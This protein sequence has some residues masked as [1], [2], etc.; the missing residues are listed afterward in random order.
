MSAE[1]LL[2]EEIC[3]FAKSLFDRG[4]TNGSSGNISARLED[5]FLV[6]P[7]G[8][9]FGSLDPARLAKLDTAQR[10]VSGDKPTKE[11]SLH[12]AFY[13][14]RG[15]QSGAVVHLHSTHSV[16]VSML[17]E[18]DPESVFPPLTPYSVM[19][20]GQVKLLPYFR[21]GDAAMGEAVQRLAGRRS[22]VLLANH[23]PVVAAKD[24][25][26]AV[27][28]AEELEEVAKLM[29]LTR[30]LN[31]KPLTRSDVADLERHFGV[32]WQD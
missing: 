5:G 24:L 10:F 26:A 20:L 15:T 9:S 18:I 11:L 22:A 29:L 12:S 25:E 31:P 32:T 3:R 28:A 23:G 14:T 30:Q 6:T 21:P 8:S 27:Y 7:T 17:P 2:R 16:A 19:R 1:A 13:D 4:L